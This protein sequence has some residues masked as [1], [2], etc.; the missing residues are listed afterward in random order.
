M[1]P[2]IVVCYGWQFYFS[3]KSITCT[4]IRIATYSNCSCAGL[5]LGTV[6]TLVISMLNHVPELLLAS[7]DAACT[8][9]LWSRLFSDF[10]AQ[11]RS[12]TSTVSYLVACVKQAQFNKA[13]Q[14]MLDET[15]LPLA[16]QTDRINLFYYG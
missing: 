15:P 12:S 7:A 4:C 1:Y 3:R 16:L 9:L 5:A 14:C 10:I 8:F 11:L 2:Y 13:T 6:Y